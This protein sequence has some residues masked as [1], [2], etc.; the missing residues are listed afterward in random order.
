MSEANKL[1]VVAFYKQTLMEGAS[2]TRFSF[3]LGPPTASTIR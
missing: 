1:A 2:K 3:M